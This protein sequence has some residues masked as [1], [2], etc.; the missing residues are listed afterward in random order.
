MS[1]E[2]TIYNSIYDNILEHIGNTPMV[3]LNKIAK[4]YG[5]ECELVAKCEF[6]NAGGSV[7]DRIG[8]RMIEGLEK[9][10]KLKPGYTVIEPTSG[11]TGIGLALASA[12][13]GYKAV[14]TLP[15]KMS[16]EKVD[17]LKALGAEI[18]RTPTEA[19]WD[20]PDSHI[21][22]SV[23]LF[24][25][26]TP[27]LGVANRLVKEIPNSMIPDQY[28]NVN[29]PL[30]HY[31]GTAVEIFRQ[32]GGKIDM[33]V[34]GAG[35]G[36]TIAGC[37]KYLKEKNPNIKIV[38]ADPVGSILALPEKL[39]E[40]GEGVSYKIEGIGYDFVPDV[41]KRQYVDEWIK[42]ED[43]ESF[44][45]ARKLIREEGLLCGGSSGTAV[46]AAVKAAKQLKKGQRCVV[47][48]P[49]SVRNYMTKFLN[50]N[51]MKE[52]GFT[53][54]ASELAAE[55]KRSQWGGAKI[56]DLNLPNAITVPTTTTCR[57][58]VEIMQSKGFDQLPVTDYST[59]KL[60][61][62]LTLGH[63]LSKFASGRA[64]PNDFVSRVM[65][66]FGI[67]KSPLKKNKTEK[68]VEITVDTPLESLSS[69]FEKHSNAVVTEGELVKHVVTK[70][71]LLNWLMK[72]H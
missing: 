16:Q 62:L 19:A 23:F 8:K 28:N 57:D 29:N 58:A 1:E 72:K 48:L 69:F 18:I 13:K 33:L 21:G 39:N 11:N 3:K 51:W 35:T 25:F 10:G 68:F 66:H 41:L 52:A 36:G 70:V 50:D 42:T 26:F 17:V 63:C 49:D 34:A 56:S 47:I 22:K 27:H 40:G 60:V 6:Y 64:T 24:S 20:S 14:I 46:I 37:G 15:E 9:D 44:L 65:F 54:D 12:V 59:K 7:K 53:D 43:K 61:G 30:A 67:D 32:C 4:F 38:A 55:R 2:K 5:L 31:H 71:D 45:M